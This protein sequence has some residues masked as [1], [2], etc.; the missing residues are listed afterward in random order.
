MIYVAGIALEYCVLA[1]CLDSLRYG[2]PVIALE[3]YIRA[4]TTDPTKL[5]E[6][7]RQLADKGIVRAQNFGPYQPRHAPAS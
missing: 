7:W 5:Q 3:P 1:T 2:V 6:V 4:A